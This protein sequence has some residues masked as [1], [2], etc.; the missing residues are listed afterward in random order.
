[1]SGRVEAAVVLNEVVSSND[2]S[3]TDEEGDNP[4][5]IE[6]FNPGGTTVDL[7]GYGLTDDLADP[8][9]WI[10]PSVQMA[11]GDY[12][13]VWASGKD[14]A[15][16]GEPLHANFAVSADGEPL[17]LSA[18]GGA[19]VD[20]LSTP[21]LESDVSYARS[22][23]GVGSWGYALD[24]TPGA[25][26]TTNVYTAFLD[27]PTFS[28]GG[29]F[30]TNDLDLVIGTSDPEA[31][32]VYTVDGSEPL[33]ERV[34]GETYTYK[35][36]YPFAPTNDFGPLLTG[37]VETV[38]YTNPL[39]LTARGS[40]SNRLSLIGTT[41]D[42]DPSYYMPTNKIEKATVIRARTVKEGALASPV[43]THTYFIHPA[44]T[45]R[46]SLPVVSFVTDEPNL[47][48]YESGIYT[49]GMDFDQWRSNNVT[50][51][52]SP[53]VP[54]NY[55]R[56]GEEWEY[57]AHVALYEVDQTN[58]V[59]SQDIGF[60]INGGYSRSVPRKSLRFFAR[61]SYGNRH[62]E[63]AVFPELPYT[64][65]RRLVLRNSGS[66][67]NASLMQDA[68]IQ[69][70]VAPMRFDTQA[71]RPTVV[72]INGSY[73]GLQ[74]FRERYGKQ[75][76]ERVYGVDPENIDLIE[77]FDSIAQEG[78][79]EHYDET[80]A[81]IETNGVADSNHF[82]Y[83]QT[84]IDTENFMDYQIAN[85]YADNTDWP[86]FNIQFWRNRTEAY[87]PDSPEGHDGR[88]RWL[89]FD[90]DA[91]F[92]YFGGS[93]AYTNNT[94]ALAL[95]DDGP[96]WPNPPYSTFLLR[97]LLENDGFRTDFINRFA[98]MLN[99]VM[100]THRAL[101]IIQEMRDILEPEVPEQINRWHRP[102]SIWSWR[103]SVGVM[104]NFVSERP[105][106]QRQH[107]QE[108]FGLSGTYTLTVDVDNPAYGHV[109]VNSIELLSDTAGVDAVPYPWEGLYFKDVPIHVTA[110]PQPGYLFTGWQELPEGH[111]PEWT[112]APTNEWILTAEFEPMPDPPV[113][114]DSI[115]QQEL[116][117]GA[118]PQVIELGTFFDSSQ[119]LTYTAEV[120]R[121]VVV[122]ASIVDD[123]LLLDPLQRG[124]TAITVAA[125]DGI[126]EPVT[127][128]FQVLV[129]PEAFVLADADFHFTEWD[130][131]HPVG[132]YPAH[133]LFLLS[134]QSDPSGTAPLAYAYYLEPDQYHANDQG[135]IGFPYNNT[136]RTRLNGLG[137]DGIS[138]INTGRDRDLGG[139]LVAVDTRGITNGPIQWLAGTINPNTRVYAIRLQYR[140]GH[141]GP[142]TDVPGPSSGPV[143]YARNAS[144][145][146]T[147]TMPVAELPAEAMGVAYVQVL[148]RYYHVTGVSGARAELRLDDVQIGDLPPRE[149]T[150][151]AEPVAGGTV[152]GG[153]SYTNGAG[154][155]VEAT[156]A[157]YFLFEQWTGDVPGGVSTNNPLSV[158]MGAPR[159]VTAH[160]VPMQTDNTGTPLWWLAAHGLT[161][162]SFETEALTDHNDN[163]VPAWMEY[164]ADIDPTNPASVWPSLRL[165]ATNDAEYVAINPTSTGR[166]YHIDVSTSLYSV[167]WSAYTN[168]AGT[169]GLWMQPGPTED[170]VLFMRGRITLPEP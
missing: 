164:V 152:A 5:W 157:P 34:G 19:V 60:R 81:Y 153:G 143:V 91:G 57:P 23:D 43:V 94:L 135:T 142:F 62:M 156:A 145:G 131:G 111:P 18:P 54:A 82:A 106:Y 63:G 158:S 11:P 61:G 90:A 167:S 53:P 89:M 127:L 150:V 126:N 161:N 70:V 17:L 58:A 118:A 95:D 166:W 119:A 85:I 149:L 78:D 140:V 24:T 27:P 42:A 69:R 41:Y 80:V 93:Q 28:A 48:D 30:Y 75:Y 98:D 44:G 123:Q 14:R 56:R 96:A 132:T 59:V 64:E 125:S 128:S 20:W 3:A 163:E 137:A 117:E 15:V 148:W 29:G 110:I 22:P 8:F 7:T 120:D 107:I 88:W 25:P 92:G 21:A 16:A 99:S 37:R 45:N 84:R 102:S 147:Q 68:A 134:A 32:I 124:G 139:A 112:G 101:G 73:W 52:A 39:T 46:Y 71:W 86:G 170:A 31:T 72:F 13:L 169:G 65:Y 108:Q 35:N 76:L 49:A 129:H 1:M 165:I 100:R 79:S 122:E 2:E 115:P 10:F 83:I 113:I 154:A 144:A 12:M 74:N 36:Q 103:W 87:E 160:F 50:D 116:I 97:S 33:P 4:D 55:T 162:A 66:T 168:A 130:P 136:G 141:T 133:M 77:N 67:E 38:V 47:F 109:R 146:H 104:T 138:F 51:E 159:N 155:V 121:A 9:Q 151:Q 26:N 114:I 6:L 40:E 105:A